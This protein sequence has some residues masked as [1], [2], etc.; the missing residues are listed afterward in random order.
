MAK[1]P[2]EKD[3]EGETGVGGGAEG[4]AV[5]VC[6]E[7]GRS[8][9]SPDSSSSSSQDSETFCF[10]LNDAEAFDG[11]GLRESLLRVDSRAGIAYQSNPCAIA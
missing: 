6:G 4:Y 11:C 3:G 9:S 2:R 10:L 5:D 8:V 7:I 1:S